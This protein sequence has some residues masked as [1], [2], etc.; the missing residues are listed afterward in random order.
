MARDPLQETA[1][2]SDFAGVRPSQV[3][4]FTVVESGGEDAERRLV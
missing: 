3:H 2:D 4:P 1:V